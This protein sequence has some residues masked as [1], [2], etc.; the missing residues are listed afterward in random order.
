[1]SVRRDLTLSVLKTVLAAKAEVSP[2]ERGEEDTHRGDVPPLKSEVGS[3]DIVGRVYF[4]SAPRGKQIDFK[5]LWNILSGQD[6]SIGNEDRKNLMQNLK[7]GTVP[8]GGDHFKWNALMIKAQDGSNPNNVVVYTYSLGPSGQYESGN[9]EMVKTG[10]YDFPD[11]D[12]FQKENALFG[13]INELQ[14]VSL[15]SGG[16]VSFSTAE[17][18][19]NVANRFL[20]ASSSQVASPSQ[21]NLND[22]TPFFRMWA[23]GVGG[24]SEGGELR[25]PDGRIAKEDQIGLNK[26][27]QYKGGSRAYQDLME[28]AGNPDKKMT[29]TEEKPKELDVTDKSLGSKMNQPVDE[30]SKTTKEQ[31]DLNTIQASD[32]NRESYIKEV[33]E[34]DSRS[35]EYVG[36][37]SIMQDLVRR[38]HKKMKLRKEAQG[39]L[40]LES[41]PATSEATKALGNS[42]QQLSKALSNAE[43]AQKSLGIKSTT[44]NVTPSYNKGLTASQVNR[45]IDLFI[46]LE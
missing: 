37:F 27:G 34:E 11:P 29:E 15:A 3:L 33:N 45:V 46:G 7:E 18:S 5:N 41:I 31:E 17:P 2:S 30:Q 22:I 21:S 13:N 8:Y 39:T 42:M 24:T 35:N 23:I 19:V 6:K 43:K 14:M 20:R 28:N 38:Q 10:D 1:M 12:S 26:R 25:L 40:D 4:Y 16:D 32:S 9:V 44:N 36:D